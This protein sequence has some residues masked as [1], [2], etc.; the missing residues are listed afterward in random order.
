ML[1]DKNI[2]LRLKVSDD[3]HREV[4]EWLETLPRNSR[5]IKNLQNVI[6]EAIRSYA[7]EKPDN[8]QSLKTQSVRCQDTTQENDH[9]HENES[10]KKEKGMPEQGT[11]INNEEEVESMPIFDLSND[12][13]MK[14][15]EHAKQIKF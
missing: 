8:I 1:K 3:T 2:Y 11:K 15:I 9:K 6:I 5:G 10:I 14:F 12:S 4:I 7:S 13:K